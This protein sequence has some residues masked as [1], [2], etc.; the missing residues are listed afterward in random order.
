M[1]SLDHSRQ[2]LLEATLAGFENS[3]NQHMPPS[4]QRDYFLWGISAHNPQQ[5][6][7]LQAI[8]FL[9]LVNLTA[10][11]LDGLVEPYLW[12]QLSD[13]TLYMNVY[14]LYEIVSDNLAI[15]LAHADADKRRNLLI[16]FNDVMIERLRGSRTPAARL[17]EPLQADAAFISTFGQ[18]LIRETHLK[19]ARLYVS[20]Y[21]EVSLETLEYG[22]WPALVANIESC[23]DL[24]NVLDAYQTGSLLRE[25]LINRYWAVN[26][27]L[28]AR[29][30]PLLE[31]AA[32]GAHSIL[33]WPTVGYY[34]SVLAEILC[35]NDYYIS[36]IEDGT[37]AEALYTAAML[38]RLLNDIGTGLLEQS[39]EQRALL[40][41]NLEKT[42]QK[43]PDTLNSIGLLLLSDFDGQALLTRIH[44]DLFHGEFNVCLHNVRHRQSV[45]DAIR[46]F[47]DNLAYYAE[48]YRQQYA[49]FEALL[50][51]IC[52]RMQE[53]TISRLLE[54]FV[55][56]HEKLYAHEYT[57]PSGEYAI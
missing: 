18:S 4:P 33:V 23:V 24:A 34:V 1:T 3:L 43:N 19:F 27:T 42:Y 29:N 30:A 39:H 51:T 21:P 47:G 46:A 36:I 17:L 49:R 35:P 57:T 53:D 5:T 54:R 25:G 6:G 41:H 7:F 14:Q 48:L 38:V 52:E 26:R 37:L 20:E 13:Y 9:Q 12:P 50:A 10:T 40:L 15:G 22:L 28:Q 56:F 31:L 32:V 8:G 11:L 45:S 44:K 16:A 2:T 55:Y